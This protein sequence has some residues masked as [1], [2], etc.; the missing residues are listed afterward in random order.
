M[1]KN[2]LKKLVV[3]LITLPLISVTCTK[4]PE[5][6][7]EDPVPIDLTPAQ[8]NL[9]ESGNS[10]AFDIFR[11]ILESADESENI[12][13]S[14]LSISYA[15]AMTLNGADGATR[16]AMLEALRINGVTPEEINGPY[17]ELTKVLLSVDKRV[18]MSIANS[19]WTENDF[20]VKKAFIDILTTY[21]DAESKSFDI[22]DPTAPD[23]INAW[24]EDKTN[25]LIKDMVDKL[26]DN[27]VMLLIN[28][29]YFKGKW[30]LQFDPDDT[31]EKP[32]YKPSGSEV[33]VQMM[34]QKED[35]SVYDGDGFL[36]AEFPYGQGNFVMD[37]IL[38][39]VKSGTADLLPSVT[40]EAFAGWANQLGER[41]VNVSIPRFK[42]DYK[43]TLKEIL[44]DMGM[45]IAF[46]DLADFTNIAETPPLL[47]ND[48]THQAFIETN[49]EGTEAAAATIVDVGVT[50]MPPPPLEFNADHSFLYIIREIETNAI[51]FMGRVAD[52]LA[53]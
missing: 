20:A 51:I 43:K 3:F 19:V 32:F 7:P 40:G 28:A 9:V 42:Y 14:P 47:I 25:G 52:P 11:L 29:I 18:I 10:F 50:S 27:T 35:F 49:E 22:E 45:G 39:D 16:E 26:N 34:K 23:K 6:L 4:T 12:I 41:E 44:T 2:I 46:T 38:P 17:N 1:K 5:D 15:L 31:S 53:D 37:I 8:L 30:K 13:I 33:N 21:Y 24:I 36:L 48:V